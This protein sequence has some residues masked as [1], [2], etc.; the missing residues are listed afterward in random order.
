MYDGA[1]VKTDFHRIYPLREVVAAQ[2]FPIKKRQ[3]GP[4]ML[5]SLFDHIADCNLLDSAR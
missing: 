4:S 1:S 2:D 5:A 3:N